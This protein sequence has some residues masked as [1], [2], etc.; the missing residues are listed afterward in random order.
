M[1]QARPFRAVVEDETGGVIIGASVVLLNAAT[2]ERREAVADA[3]GRIAFENVA[4]GNYMLTVESPGFKALEQAVPIGAGSPSSL[5]HLKLKIEVTDEVSV[6]A[7]R[8]DPR[9]NP[10]ADDL[11]NG[12]IADLPLPMGSTQLLDVLGMFLSPALQGTAGVAVVVDGGEQGRLSVPGAAI[13]RIV[14][15]KSPFSAEYKKPGPA[16]VEIITEDGSRRHFEANMGLSFNSSIFDARNAFAR[17]KPDT[18]KTLFEG[19]FS[20]PLIPKRASFFSTWEYLRDHQSAVVN[21]QTPGG[22]LIETVPTFANYASG[23]GRLD[24]K[25][26][27]LLNVMVRYDYT[28]EIQRNRGVGGLRLPSLAVESRDI[29]HGLRLR[30]N[31]IFSP[32]LANDL[33]VSVERETNREGGPAGGPQLLVRGAF[34]GGF[35]QTFTSDRSTELLIQDTATYFRGAHTMRV[36][37]RVESNFVGAADRS[38][39][40]GVFEFARL[41]LFGAGVPSLFRINQGTPDVNFSVWDADV[42]FQDDIK[43]APSF[44]LML[45]G[46][47][48]W[49]SAVHDF[50]KVVPRLGFAWSSTPRTVVRGGAGV[51]YER[52]TE[53]LLRRSVLFDGA[54]TTEL[55]IAN[56]GYPDPFA[57][58]QARTTLPSVVRLAPDIGTPRLTHA[59]V[60]LERNVWPKAFLTLEYSHLRGD[61]LYRTRNINAPLPGTALRPDLRFVNVNQIE[62]SAGL[63]SNAL[64]VKLAGRIGG[65]IKLTTNYAYS[66]STND[67]S[68][69]LSLPA[70]NYDLGPE[71][72]RAEFDIRHRF[73][74][75]TSLD[76]PARFTLGTA[77]SLNSGPPYD[78]TTGFD[79]N[80]DTE[81]TDRPAGF[82][83]NSGQGFGFAQLDLRLLKKIKIGRSLDADPAETGKFQFSVDVF[84]ILNRPNYEQVI[85]VQSSPLFGRPNSAR[86]SRTIQFSTKYSF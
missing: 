12:L 26:S 77:L 20:G 74:L 47:Y 71:R 15:N 14:V 46:R 76:L 70:N 27:Q 40:G 24:F 80:G 4:P 2:Q 75:L 59:S 13:K 82:V 41:D 65:K 52:L 7:L 78:I 22:P 84:N 62:S 44:T 33:R 31:A 35:S 6:E 19:G 18:D 34:R 10:E 50:N 55:V 28:G 43:V 63:R 48:D 60:S 64:N 67:A 9:P 8:R 42:F 58:G 45:G 49:Q 66:R 56:P 37:G 5:V 1:A 51:F 54:H 38:N 25:P 61:Q 11:E 68:G 73:N 17:T 23:L 83:R 86:G 79:D 85:G 16:R 53:R 3:A 72:G 36:G 21:A 32:V 57:S 29:E 69:P 39:F 81:A 30:A